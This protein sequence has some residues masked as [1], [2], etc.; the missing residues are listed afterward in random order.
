MP[1][2]IPAILVALIGAALP[3]STVCAASK[4]DPWATLT[5]KPSWQQQ[6]RI[7]FRTIRLDPDTRQLHY[8]MRRRQREPAQQADSRTCRALRAVM[9]QLKQSDPLATP[10]PRL[11]YEHHLHTAICPCYTLHCP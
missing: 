10:P 5:I 8:W 6:T 1:S 7:E 11:Q 3:L 9:G 2:K 4:P